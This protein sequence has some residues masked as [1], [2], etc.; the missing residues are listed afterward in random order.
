MLS[1][2]PTIVVVCAALAAFV[3]IGLRGG[4]STTPDD[5]DDFTTARG[6]QGPLSLALSFVASGLGAWILFAP[7]ELGALLGVVPVVGYALAAAAPFVLFA[8]LGPRLR[9]VLPDGQGLGQFVRARF[10]S[11]ASGAVTSVSVL[12]MGVFVAAELVAVGGLVELVGGVPRTLTVPAVLVATL[13]YTA[14]GGLRASLRTDR[15]QA[16]LVVLLLGAAAAAALAGTD[17]AVPAVRDAGLLRVDAAGLQAAATLVLA[18]TAANMFHHG[19]WQRVWSARDD[20]A[21]RRGALAGAALTVPLVLLAGGLGMLGAA[22]GAADAPA[23]SLFAFAARLPGP[24]VVVVLLLGTC[25]VASSLDTLEN[26]LAALVV[27][28]RPGTGLGAARVL[29]VLVVLP[30]A[31]VALVATSVL[32]LFLVADLLAAVLLLPVLLGLWHRTTP[33]ALRAGIAAGIVGAVG[34]GLLA[35]G[36]WA[37]ALAAVTFPDAVPTLPPFLGAVVAGGT[38]TL[39]VSLLPGGA[40]PAT[41][42]PEPAGAAGAA[43]RAGP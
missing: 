8:V 18:V 6:S 11:A 4:R 2:T 12:Y 39:L 42:D 25:L 32:Q 34:A 19:Y 37:G 9:R 17:R 27:A 7:P 20:G 36:T 5:V 16:V 26:G 15:W 43:G 35:T 29:T 24:V 13:A 1:T 14:Y 21:L 10:G 38:V 30:A 41:A 23:L 40:R 31:A 3:L 28:G 22:T 33:T